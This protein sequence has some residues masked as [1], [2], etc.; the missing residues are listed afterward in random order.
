MPTPAESGFRHGWSTMLKLRV[1]MPPTVLA[2][3]PN[4]A[5]VL[6]FCRKAHNDLVLLRASSLN[7]PLDCC[8][9]LLLSRGR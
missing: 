7:Q 3:M 2:I 6:L 8:A 5:K 4:R 9:I 1:G